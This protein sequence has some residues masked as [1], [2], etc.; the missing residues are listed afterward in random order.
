GVHAARRS[1]RGGDH[2]PRGLPVE[3]HRRDVADA[4]LQADVE[5]H[6]EEQ[7][8]EGAARRRAVIRGEQQIDAEPGA[9]ADAERAR[10]Q[11]EG[12]DGPDARAETAA[13]AAGRG[14]AEAE[15]LEEAADLQLDALPP[16]LASLGI[17]RRG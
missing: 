7:G 11:R 13:A 8:E 1:G 16:A 2:D 15:G 5:W 17:R 12:K 10:A 9:Q 6:L 14:G 4:Q 3:A